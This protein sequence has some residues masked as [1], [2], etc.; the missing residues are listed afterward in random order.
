METNGQPEEESGIKKKF[1]EY[2]KEFV[3][4]FLAVFMGFVAENIR[5]HLSDNEK[6]QEYVESLVQ[7]LQ[8]DTAQLKVVIKYSKQQVSGL[9]SL[10]KVSKNK[11]EQPIVQDSLYILTR[12]YLYNT[13]EFKNNDVTLSQLRNAGGFGFIKSATALDSIAVF[14]SYLETTKEQYAAT[15]AIFVRARER[16]LEL[17]DL[18]C[19][20]KLTGY[21]SCTRAMISTDKEKVAAYFNGCWMARGALRAYNG[22]LQDGLDY[23]ER[24]IAFLK[25]EY[26]IK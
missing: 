10:I 2:F 13:T 20:L 23:I 24:L 6:G 4:M 19:G 12:K 25:K 18:N 8:S 1:K 22:M 14:E 5:E 16:S 3:M 26:K 9:D 15:T 7:N 21:T 11:L 17:L